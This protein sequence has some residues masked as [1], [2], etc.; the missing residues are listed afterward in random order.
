MALSNYSEL[1]ASIA[2]FLNRTDLTDAIKDFITLCEASLNRDVEHWQREARTTF[3]VDSRYEDVPSD[4]WSTMR[5]YL[6]GK[7][8]PLQPMSQS[9]MQSERDATNDASGE[10]KYYAITAGQFEFYPTPGDSYTG[11][12]NY[13]QKIPAL[14]DSNTSNWL[15]DDY[16]DVYLYGSLVHSAGYLVEDERLR[17]WAA[18]Y[19]QA[20]RQMNKS[21]TDGKFGSNLRIR[22][23]QYWS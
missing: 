14:S 1:Q 13:I 18:L 10:P 16:P 15:L 19:D 3:T 7:D 9:E 22:A 12:L 4:Y 17:T 23:N 8:W 5:L 6:D 20:L 2:D 11:N 21:G